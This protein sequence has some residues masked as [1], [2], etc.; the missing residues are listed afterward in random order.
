MKTYMITVTGYDWAEDGLIPVELIF[1]AQ[2]KTD[3]DA[4]AS[5]TT[6]QRVRVLHEVTNVTTEKM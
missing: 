2:G 4:I 6:G 5:I 3:E 1:F